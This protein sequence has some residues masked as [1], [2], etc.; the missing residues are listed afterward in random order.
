MLS[1]CTTP[2]PTAS[3]EAVALVADALGIDLDD[4]TC[5]SEY[6]QTTS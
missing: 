3:S 6:A 1:E 5:V 4:I 2:L